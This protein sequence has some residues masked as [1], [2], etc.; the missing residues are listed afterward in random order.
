M[1]QQPLLDPPADR[2]I[3]DEADAL[4]ARGRAGD[5]VD[6]LAPHVGREPGDVDAWHRMARARLDLGDAPGAMR[7]AW[8]AWQQ[9]PDGPESLFWISRSCSA[10]GDH[11]EAIQT[12][13]TAC[14]QDPGNPRLHNRLG[15][16]QLA[17]GRIGDAVAGLQVAV[18]LAG[19][20]ADLQVT[21]GL[22]LFAAGRPLSARE[23]V[24]RALTLA[25]GHEGARSALARFEDAMRQ[26][27]D[28]VSLE[29][30]ADRFA[31]SL[32]VRPGAR[33][34]TAGRDAFA[35]AMRVSF[36]WFFTAFLGV[37][38]LDLLGL[39]AVPEGLYLTLLCTAG[40]FAI[41]AR[42]ARPAL[43]HP[44]S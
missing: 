4:L 6:L 34:R 22:A 17:D 20:D 38:A 43:P 13:A 19:Y 30:A 26:V 31:E 36:V 14:R 40:L 29:Q 2:P 7:A 27:V 16:A 41:V 35:Y 28:A 37:G 39:V 12:A 8:A 24:A 33:R 44:L 9:D 18:E 11:A 42:L 5:V 3:L 15:E 32:R 25:P 23:A 21:Y 1:T 10:S